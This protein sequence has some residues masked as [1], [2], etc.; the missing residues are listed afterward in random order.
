M[1]PYNRNT[2]RNVLEKMNSWGG[3]ND[4]QKVFSTTPLRKDYRRIY[5]AAPSTGNIIQL[6]QCKQIVRPAA[7]LFCQPGFVNLRHHTL[8]A[9]SFLTRSPQCFYIK[10]II[11]MYLFANKHPYICA[12][13]IPI[14]WFTTAITVADEV[15]LVR[16]N[17][18]GRRSVCHKPSTIEQRFKTAAK[19]RLKR[20]W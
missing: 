18:V 16:W 7:W 5:V 8:H 9:F 3:H 15:W 13:G 11:S 2:S 6:F 17:R 19:S 12:R 1:P 10:N 14:S 20:P 4:A